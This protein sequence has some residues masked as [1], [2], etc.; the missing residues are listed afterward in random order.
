MAVAV[1][2][3]LFLA[4]GSPRAPSRETAGADSPESDPRV[5]AAR[6]AWEAKPGTSRPGSP[7]RTR[8]PRPA[9]GTRWWT[10]SAWPSCGAGGGGGLPLREDPRRARRASAHAEALAADPELAGPTGRRSGRLAALRTGEA[11]GRHWPE[12]E[13]AAEEVLARGPR[14]GT[15][16]FWVGRERGGEVEGAVAAYRKVLELDPADLWTRN[17]LALL[18][19][20]SGAKEEAVALAR[21]TA[22]SRAELASAHLH[23]GLVLCLAGDPRPGREA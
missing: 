8:W 3:A 23:L 9:G 7:S 12:A 10:S 16:R 5:A 1:V 22:E 11:D 17:A 14:R 6:S 18:L 2:P 13:A 21:A 15:G 4:L 19:A 20:K